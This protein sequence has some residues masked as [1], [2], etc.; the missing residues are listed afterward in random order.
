MESQ[1][2]LMLALQMLGSL[3]LLIFGMKMMSETLQKMAGPQLRHILGKMTT[4]RFTGMFTGMFVTAAVQSSTATTVMT[5]SFVNAG[6][7]TLAQAISVIMG[8]NI[9]TTLTAWIMSAGFAF[10]ITDLVWPGFIIAI[11]LIYRKKNKNIGDFIFGLAFLFLGLG[12]LRATGMSMKL[13]EQ[14]AVLDFFQSFDPDSFWTTILFLFIGGI[15]TM[16]CQSS[17]AVMA[18]TMILCS[19]G[20]LPIYQGIA[21]VMGE[22]IGTTV[23]SNLAALSASTQAR[24]AAFAHMFFN[25]FGV[26][27]ILIIFKPFINFV[28][29]LV[30][31][32]VEMTRDNVDAATFAG[33]T[34]KLSV[35]LATFH[36]FFNV[37]NTFILIW[38][39]PQIEKLVCAVIKGK[40]KGSEE[41]D[42]GPVRL[43]YIEGGLMATPEISVYQAQKEVVVFGTRMQ[44]MFGMVKTLLDET[45]DEAYEK[46]FNRIRKYEDIGDNMEVEIAR[47]LEKVSDSQLSEDTMM[48]LHALMRSISELESVGDAC[49]NMARIIQ[50]LK[51]KEEKFTDEQTK[52]I[53]K[54]IDLTDKALSQMLVV[55]KGRRENL[56]T[57]ESYRIERD[58]NQLRDQ[59]KLAN[60]HDINEHKYSYYLGTA[61]VDLL[62]ECERLGDYVM[63]VVE[64]KFSKL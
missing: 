7:L 3:A 28:C 46:N 61:Y 35:V 1:S 15:L 55:L 64:S 29:S 13:G 31:F 39:I 17:A 18:I 11:F 9:G 33:N 41:D 56:T 16:C 8:A 30:G 4:N 59:L 40:K 44:R 27:W 26:V 22:N 48:K 14:P 32:D 54:M 52:N 50:R 23:T 49:Y 6:L 19:S 24:R 5:V 58:I 51:D 36:T 53:H 10:S 2:T 45:D 57:K 21:L 12:T 60:V 25:V 34:A 63:N 62:N 37:I 38:F 20:A 42:E 47:Y 43:K